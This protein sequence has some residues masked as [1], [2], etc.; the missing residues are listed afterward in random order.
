MLIWKV[1]V[2]IPDTFLPLS[3][4]ILYLKKNDIRGFFR[5]NSTVISITDQQVIGFT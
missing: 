2:K 3:V 4:S 5:A 1:L